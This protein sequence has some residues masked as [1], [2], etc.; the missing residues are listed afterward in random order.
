MKNSIACLSLLAL[1]SSAAADPVEKSRAW[2]ESYPVATAMPRL[3]VRNIWGNVR[4]RP[5]SPG[6]ISVTIDE[7]RSAPTQALFEHSLE[8]LK[9]D[10]VADANGATFHVGRQNRSWE[11]RDRCPGCRVDYQFEVT[12]PPG[13]RLDVGTVTDGGID[14]AGVVGTISASNVNGPITVS[15]LRDCE[16]LESVNGAVDLSFAMAPGQDCNIETV[17]GDITL[18]MP[19]GTGLDI[20]LDLFN[21][22]MTTEFQVDSYALPA[23]VEHS[24]DNGRHRYRIQQSAGLRLEGGGP[25]FSIS[26]LNGDIRFQKNQIRRHQ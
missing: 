24:T 1:I 26:S 13:T 5:G 16:G 18:V 8:S 12:V 19:D 4:V 17:N 7:K 14:V 25:T 11:H 15:E 21:G 20:A 9:L 2:T 22:R 23:Q 6:A 10:V 3:T